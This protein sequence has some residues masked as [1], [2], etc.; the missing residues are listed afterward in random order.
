MIV[1]SMFVVK[2]AARAPPPGLV[3]G[4]WFVLLSISVLTTKITS[5][6]TRED[7]VAN[8]SSPQLVLFFSSISF[9]IAWIHNPIL[10]NPFCNNLSHNLSLP[11]GLGHL[12]THSIIDP[13]INEYPKKGT[14]AKVETSDF[15]HLSYKV[16][17][18]I[19]LKQLEW[20]SENYQGNTI[21][22][23]HTSLEKKA[24]GYFHEINLLI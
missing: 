15:Q 9:F 17:D 2:A 3:P 7:A 1:Y 24:K 5:L 12:I 16:K 19:V 20:Q 8:P 18:K 6:V 4:H 13:G 23:L 21:Y 11:L 14:K 10:N 22:I